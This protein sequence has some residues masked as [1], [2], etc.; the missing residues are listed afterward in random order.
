MIFPNL[1]SGQ[2]GGNASNSIEATLGLTKRENLKKLTL[3][4]MG[5]EAES[6][7]VS[8]NVTADHRSKYSNVMGKF[9]SYFE[10]W[11]NTI[12]ERARFN[13]KAKKEVESVEQY[14]IELYDLVEFCAYGVLKDEMLRNRLVIGI[15]DLRLSEKLQTDPML[16]LEKAKTLIMQKAA[17]KDHG[18]ELQLHQMG[19]EAA[20]LGR[21]GGHKP[22]LNRSDNK[23]QQTFFRQGQKGLQCTR[24]D[25][26]NHLAEDK[27]PATGAICHKCFKKRAF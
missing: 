18:H 19:S 11:R 23:L 2:N 20:D 21:L 17:M 16:T 12:F 25:H 6:V 26:D 14:I 8:T 27:C 15:R 24:C 22:I 13:R 7:L 3:Y 9:D 4:C 5:E 1:T 10:V